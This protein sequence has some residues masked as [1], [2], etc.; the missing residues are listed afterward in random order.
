LNST[1]SE[2]TYVDTR[3]WGITAAGQLAPSRARTSPCGLTGT[4]P[5][6]GRR[7]ARVTISSSRSSTCSAHCPLRTS[8]RHRRCAGDGTARRPSAWTRA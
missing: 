5:T 2:R 8:S 1:D 4:R 6:S 3:Q 7:T